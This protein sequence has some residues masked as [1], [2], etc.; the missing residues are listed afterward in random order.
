MCSYYKRVSHEPYIK[1]IENDTIKSFR[2]A[3]LY[4]TNVFTSTGLKVITP[5]SNQELIATIVMICV[6]QYILIGLTAEFATMLVQGK[7]V[8]TKFEREATCV[9]KYLESADLSLSLKNKVWD[10]YIILWTRARGP[11]MPKLISEAP[12]YIKQDIMKNLFGRHINDHFL[13][14]CTH[15]DFQRQLVALFD[16]C[17]FPPGMYIV[18]KGDVDNCMYFIDA[19]EIIVYDRIDKKEVE[20]D[21]LGIGEAFGEAQGLY[22]I[23]HDKSYKARFTSKIVILNKKKWRYLLDW[24]PA[25]KEHIEEQA[26]RKLKLLSLGGHSFYV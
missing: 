17:V 24:F 14:K 5:T 6:A 23:P 12:D 1:V 18:Q 19:G 4:V 8:M 3:Y 11:W 20:Y 9:L 21:V 13:F 15:I 25:S 10:Y 22:G 16:V 26:S 2:L 7:S